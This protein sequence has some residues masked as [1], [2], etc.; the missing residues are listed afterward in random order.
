M[1]GLKSEMGKNSMDKLR[2]L[3]VDDHA[4][5]RE[6]IVG[7]LNGQP[8]IEVVGEASDGLE[9]LVLARSLHPAVILMDIN[10]PGTDGI[11]ATRLIKRELPDAY[12]VMLTVRDEDAKL[13]EAIKSG[14]QGYLPKTIRAQQL[15]DMLHAAQRGEPTISPPLANR[16]LDE[17]RRVATQPA[18]TPAE[19]PSLDPLTPREREVLD[20]VA[21]GASDRVIAQELVISVYTVK[22]H[23]R[24]ILNK[25]QVSSRRQAARLAKRE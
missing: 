22:A 23:M 15:I 6:G 19:S 7:I 11:E 8:D 1:S 14:A 21:R 12:V 17:F 4:L 16:I 3:V 5:F 2:V 9:A 20:L 24:S 10:M 18:T 25:L 13:L